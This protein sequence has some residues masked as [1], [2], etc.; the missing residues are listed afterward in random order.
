[1]AGKI[2]QMG[3]FVACDVC[4]RWRVNARKVSASNEYISI[5]VHIITAWMVDKNWVVYAR[6]DLSD[7]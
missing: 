1:M 6:M 2:R 4:R 7:C 3:D 5:S